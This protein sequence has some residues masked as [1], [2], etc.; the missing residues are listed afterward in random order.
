M[1]WSH[2]LIAERKFEII[3]G[4]IRPEMINPASV[5]ISVGFRYI[6]KSISKEPLTLNGFDKNNPKLFEPGAFLLVET[7]ETLIVPADAAI[8]LK[9]KST[10][11]R[12]GWNHSLAFWFD[13]GWYGI[14]TMEIKNIC[15]PD[16]PDGMLP[17]YPGMPFAQIIIH[18]L[19]QPTKHLYKGRYQRA[20]TVEGA[21]N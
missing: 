9:L 16:D 18:K 21:K 13:P 4:G 7:L 8:E 10:T 17:L 1:I 19:D 5:D 11:A 15:E 14:G 6:R 2:E 20:Q 3:E 12:M